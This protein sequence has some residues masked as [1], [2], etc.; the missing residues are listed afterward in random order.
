[1]THKDSRI[2]LVNEILN[3]I[4]VR[5]ETI[6]SFLWFLLSFNNMHNGHATLIMLNTAWAANFP[7][8]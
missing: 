3:G 4:K 1:M 2:K 6:V 7:K 5:K 8:I